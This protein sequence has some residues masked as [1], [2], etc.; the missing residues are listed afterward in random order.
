MA[1]L[2]GYVLHLR[3]SI[4]R[5]A[6]DYNVI[7]KLELFQEFPQARKMMVITLLPSGYQKTQAAYS[8]PVPA[9]QAHHEPTCPSSANMGN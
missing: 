1:K 6:V 8:Q 4:Q 5:G 9:Q 7:R 2:K 3:S